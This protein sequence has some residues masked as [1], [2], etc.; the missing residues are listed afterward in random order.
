MTQT[1][2]PQVGHLIAGKMSASD[3]R[4]VRDPGR[5]DDVVAQVAVGTVDD[6]D[7]AVRAA[8]AAYPVWRDTSAAE[9]AQ[10]LLVAAETLAGSGK[11]HA[12]LLVR[13]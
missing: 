10:Q 9:R 4:D 11:E 5:L 6:A 3:I 8:H 7:R 13:E 12:P 1:T 2:V